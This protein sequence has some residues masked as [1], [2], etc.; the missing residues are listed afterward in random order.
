M[1]RSMNLLA[2]FLIACSLALTQSTEPGRQPKPT[3]PDLAQG[4]R[5]YGTECS[6]CHGPKGEGAV[7]PALAVPRIRRAPTDAALFQVIREGIAG[8]QMPPSALTPA[9]LWQLVAYVRT[10]GHVE[11]S[12]S[13]GDARQGEQVYLAKGGCAHCHTL[14]GHGGAI[15]PDLS[16]A[17]ARLDSEF[18]RASLMTPEASI[19]RDFMQVRLVTK[20][21]QRLT[22]VRVNEDSFSIQI[23]DLSN[24]FHSFWKSELTELVK[25]NGRS[26]MPSYAKTLT[27]DELENL[28]AYLESLQGN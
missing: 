22:G 13:T 2:G 14:R 7:G 20:G 21:G 23:R 28:I 15:G 26:P 1:K 8:T 5:T 27:P 16:D 19:P 9:Q 17:G 25:E 4:E 10:L 6:F 11:Q 18:I 3:P 12:K 24:Q